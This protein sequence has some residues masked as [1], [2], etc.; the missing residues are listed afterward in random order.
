MRVVSVRHFCKIVCVCVCVCVCVTV[1]VCVCGFWT[2][3]GDTRFWAWLGD[4]RFWAWLG[5]V[6][7]W[8]PPTLFA[9]GS[10]WG[11]FPGLDVAECGG[12]PTPV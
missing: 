5:D 7:F 9:M 4:V 6:R 12:P 2:W 3:L 10:V 11:L 8:G 1:C